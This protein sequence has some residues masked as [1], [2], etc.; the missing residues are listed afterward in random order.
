[1]RSLCATGKFG[2]IASDCRDEIYCLIILLQ[3]EIDPRSKLEPTKQIGIVRTEPNCLVE[4]LKGSFKLSEFRII[5][6]QVRAGVRLG[7]VQSESALAFSDR[8]VPA[9]LEFEYVG[10]A[11]VKAG[12]IWIKGERSRVQFV[13]PL[14]VGFRVGAGAERNR[15]IEFHGQKAQ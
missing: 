15:H 7:R 10:L 3:P 6:R 8:I 1:M 12:E 14:K 11:Q 2:L 4:I 5:P 13:G 9:P